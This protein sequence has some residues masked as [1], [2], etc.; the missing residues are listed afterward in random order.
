MRLNTKKNV[1]VNF[2][3]FFSFCN[4]WRHFHMLIFGRNGQDSFG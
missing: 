4:N 3:Y 1:N 2:T